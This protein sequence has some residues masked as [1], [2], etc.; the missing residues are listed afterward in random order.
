MGTRQEDG[1]E[2]E[3][4]RAHIWSLYS[5]GLLDGDT[6]TVRLLMV[7][8]DQRRA[9]ATLARIAAPTRYRRCPVQATLGN[10]PRQRRRSY[11]VG[12]EEWVSI[13]IQASGDDE[14]ELW[15]ASTQRPQAGTPEMTVLRGPEYL[16]VATLDRDGWIE[17]EGRMLPEGGRLRWF[18]R[19]ISS[20]ANGA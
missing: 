20:P 17:R 14:A 10:V 2:W 19:R 12:A 6:A 1:W 15:T 16:L 3:Q 5:A 9:R 4:R 8:R 18:S 7:D 13:R 11:G